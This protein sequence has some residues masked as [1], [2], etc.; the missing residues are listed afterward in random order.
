[1][2]LRVLSPRFH[3]T[4]YKTGKSVQSVGRLLEILAVHTGLKFFLVKAGCRA[5]KER[6][7]SV[8]ESECDY[9]TR[10]VIQSGVI[11]WS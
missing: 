10:Q 3:G 9:N 1:M 11:I 8:T 2:F 7:A 6:T 4:L 5:V